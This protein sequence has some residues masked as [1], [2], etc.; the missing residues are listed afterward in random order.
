MRFIWG[1]A[2]K[3]LRRRARDPFALALYLGIPIVI[4]LLLYL[5]FGRS[6]AT[7]R[8][9]LLIADEDKTLIS[10]LL[11]GMFSQG[12]LAEMITVEKVEQGAGRARLGKG[13][14]SALLIVPKGFGSAVLKN[15]P[16]TL[17]LITNPAQRILPGIIEEAL[18][19][20]VE[21]AFY[22]QLLVGDQ[23]R[24]FA[25]GPPS[26]A[27]TFPDQTIADVSVTFNRLGQRLQKYLDPLLIELETKVVEERK[28]AQLNFA[29]A[30]FPT[31]VFM[32]LLFMAQGQSEDIW[33]EQILG[34][35]RRAAMTPRSIEAFLAGKL[36]SV[37]GV[38]APISFAALLAG[39]WIIGAETR[40]FLPA[41]LWLTFS[42]TSLFLLMLL[43]Q[44]HASSA[45]TGYMI[46]SLVM[47]PLLML[48]G[49][50]FPFEA[51][52][53]GLAA[54][55]RWTPNGWLLTQFKAILA[56]AADPARLASGAAV[57]ISF[58]ALAFWLAARRARRVLARM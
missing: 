21:A 40:N 27:S 7:P 44:V 32:S 50:F 4:A 49:S 16:F 37:V 34:T 12:K 33:R 31:I 38:V 53:A 3:D 14:A 41:L 42:G 24:I 57:W 29:A 19:I 54:V 48:G 5:V 46:T 52:P 30:F 35:L 39:R 55:G 23:L 43:A 58:C 1:T 2:A 45:R 18:S 47:F 9:L 11:S 17:S 28:E 6:G 22:L 51:M 36:L 25:S 26:G 20:V 10:S 8:G 13:E 56:G 15:E